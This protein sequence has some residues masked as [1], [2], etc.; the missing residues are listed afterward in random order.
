MASPLALSI[1]NEGG[2]Y[3]LQQ[4]KTLFPNGPLLIIVLVGACWA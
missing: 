2:K 4:H 3:I 1:I